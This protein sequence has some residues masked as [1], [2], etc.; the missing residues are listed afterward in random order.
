M[1]EE[2]LHYLNIDNESI[3]SDFLVE[4]LAAFEGGR[5][6][7]AQDRL[8]LLEVRQLL[9]EVIILLLLVYHPQLQPVVQGLHEWSGCLHDLLADVLDLGLHGGEVLSVEFDQLVVLLQVLV[10]FPGQVL[11]VGNLT[12]T[13]PRWPMAW[14]EFCPSFSGELLSW[15][16][17]IQ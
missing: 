5:D 12:S 10:G 1:G 6:H 8:L 11:N 17:Q 7:L 16:I 15:L 14:V 9:L 3:V 4:Y 13:S 2:S